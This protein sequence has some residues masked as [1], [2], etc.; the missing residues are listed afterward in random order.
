L[1]QGEYGEVHHILPRS[2]GGMD[3]SQN[4]VKL[5]PEEHY[6]CHELLPFIYTEG[7]DHIKM[8]YAWNMMSGRIKG[9]QMS[10]DVYGQLKRS[11]STMRSLEQ[12]RVA[13]TQEWK[14]HQSEVH[15]GKP[16]PRKG[17]HISEETKRKISEAKKGKK[18]GPCS[19]ET[20]QKISKANKGN[21]YC[22][23]KHRSEQFKRKIAESM[24]HIWKLRKEQQKCLGVA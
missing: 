20:R 17:V 19:E 18:H 15:K 23:G 14:N 22:K 16:S 21:Q 24:K 4:L 9:G 13:S 8:L 5:T 6:R 12:K 10:A 11:F 2:L 1:K 7:K 3:I